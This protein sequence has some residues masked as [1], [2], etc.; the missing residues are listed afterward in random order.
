MSTKEDKME[1]QNN[2]VTGYNRF[3]SFVNG[4]KF[5]TP[6]FKHAMTSTGTDADILALEQ[7]L[8]GWCIAGAEMADDNVYADCMEANELISHLHLSYPRYAY[9][10]YLLNV[11]VA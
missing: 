3:N 6:Q 9:I 1:Q 5:K 4:Y 11:L 2:E 7:L 10:A 8:E